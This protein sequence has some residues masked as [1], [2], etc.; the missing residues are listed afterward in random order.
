MMFIEADART[1]RCCGPEG[2]GRRK[3]PEDIHP[4][5]SDLEHRPIRFCIGSDCMAWRFVV[6]HEPLTQD[7]LHLAGMAGRLAQALKPEIKP[8]RGYCGLAGEE[9]AEVNE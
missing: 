9:N 4:L 1:K 5:A 2:C 8:R 6:E 7:E 3:L